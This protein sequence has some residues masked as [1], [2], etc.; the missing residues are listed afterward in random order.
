MGFFTKNSIVPLLKRWGVLERFSHQE[1][2]VLLSEK[3]PSLKD[4]L[5]NAIGLEKQNNTVDTDLLAASIEKK[6]LLSLKYDF[7][8]SVSFTDHK[9]FILYVVG[10]FFFRNLLMGI[11]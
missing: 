3:I 7:L 11:S 1:A 6:S 4:H 10:V 8:S 2:A 9:K 5:V